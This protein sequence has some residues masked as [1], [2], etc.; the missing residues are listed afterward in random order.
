LEHTTVDEFIDI[1]YTYSINSPDMRNA[2]RSA[3]LA[4]VFDYKT[5]EPEE[6]MTFKGF[7]KNALSMLDELDAF[8]LG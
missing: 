6:E 8:Q 7:Q 2:F 1:V 3:M 4:Y 5:D